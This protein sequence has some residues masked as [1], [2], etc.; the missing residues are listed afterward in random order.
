MIQLPLDKNDPLVVGVGRH[1]TCY[2]DPEDQTKC[3]KVIHN[4]SKHAT[5]ELRRELSYYKH[6]GSYLK[7]WRGIPKYYGQIE[8]NLGGGYLY[9]RI[10]DFDGKPSKTMEQR[11]TDLSSKVFQSELTDL[12]R[13]LERYLWDNKIVTMTIKPY[14]ILCHRVTETEVFPVICDNIGTASFVPIEVY[15][16]W[17][18]H[19]KQKRQFKKFERLVASKFK[20]S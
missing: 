4:P 20:L 6:L 7:D 11:Y 14:N 8:T 17:F 5:E 9:D 19:L 12:I 2:I 13:N 18:C 15:C 10:I 3:I 1:R 16:P